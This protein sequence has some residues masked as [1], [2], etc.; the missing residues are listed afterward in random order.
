M[1]LKSIANFYTKYENLNLKIAFVLI[2]LQIIHLYWL[3]T[4]VVLQRI[5]GESFLFLSES[6]LP[7]FIVI[8]Y[9]E[10]P[11]LA[12]GI[13]FYALRAYNRKDARSALFIVLLGLQ[14]FHIYWLTDDIVYDLLFGT[15]LVGLPVWAAWIGILIDYLEI[16]VILDLFR[17]VIKSRK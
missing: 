4:D 1:V 3:T 10:I 2:A 9:L 6:L 11:A 15:A 16:P 17:R 8:D 5:T 14:F 7:L 13:T 12:S